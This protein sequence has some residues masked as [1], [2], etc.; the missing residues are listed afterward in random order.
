MSSS[1]KGIYAAVA[2]NIAIA[3]AKLVG[4]AFTGSSAMLSEAIH[5]VVDTGNGALLL[6]GL[7]RSARP[8]DETHPFGYGKELYFWTLIVALLIFVLGGGISMAEGIQHIRQPA[9]A[10]D[11]TWSYAILGFAFLF[12]GYALSVSVRE[13]RQ[14]APKGSL[15]TA[16]HESKDPSAFT[17][18]F[19]DTAALLGLMAAFLGLFLGHTFDWPLA[20]G[21]ASVVIGALL[22]VVAVLLIVESKDLLIGEGARR[23]M[24]RDIRSLASTDPYVVAVGAPLTMYFGPS[25]VLLAMELQFRSDLLPGA[26]EQAIDRIE[27]AIRG[28]YPEI[29]AIYLE[30]NSLRARRKA[31]ALAPIPQAERIP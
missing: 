18:I 5:S 7:R 10:A 6:L 15:I 3:A 25:N 9:A 21:I 29:R 26:I 30:A 17:V 2:A 28:R 8:P 20:D 13:F 27:A 22:L 11:P 24:L 23:P 4:F 1:R 16:I 19:E 31:D 12:E 14:A